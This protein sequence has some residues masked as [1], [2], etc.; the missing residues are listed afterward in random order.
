MKINKLIF[1]LPLFA[2]GQVTAQAPVNEPGINLSYMDRSVRPNDDFFRFVNGTWIDNTE[3]PAD[4]TRWGSFD[5]LR[6]RTDTDALA[7]LNAAAKNPKFKSDTDQGK[8][9]GLYKTILDTVTR[10]K[11]GIAPLKPYLDKINAVKNMADLQKLMIS[12]EPEGGIGFTGVGISADA[13]NSNRNVVYVG[14]GSVGLPDR[15][16]YVS[17]DADSKEKR[18]K[19]V[20]HVARMLQYLGEKPATAKA[21]AQRILALETAMSE[22]RLDRVERRDR[23]K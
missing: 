23:R 4:R 7:I 5:A 10:N 8:A 3:I 17:D 22:P 6:Q 1:A 16:Y 14:L 2:I 19:Y 20:A 9:V 21:N 15:D 13:K 12:S 11:Q 18:E